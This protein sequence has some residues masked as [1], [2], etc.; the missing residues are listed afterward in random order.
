MTGKNNRDRVA[1]LAGVSSATVSR[2]YNNPQRVSPAKKEAV[3]K[4]ARALGY[5]PD[6][7]ASALRRKGT[8]FISLVSFEKQG[9]PWYWGDFPGAKWFFTD[10]LTGILSVVDSSMFRLN[11]KTLK[12]PSHIHKHNWEQE[13]DGVI[14]LM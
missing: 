9:R 12:T 4:A 11:L 2:V 5:S 13:C 14:F 8:G 10:V 1:S 7:S 3:L 6:K